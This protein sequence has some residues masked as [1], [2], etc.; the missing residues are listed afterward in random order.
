MGIAE[1]RDAI[2]LLKKLVL[3]SGC[4]IHSLPR[5]PAID[6]TMAEAR[7]MEKAHDDQ[8]KQMFSKMFA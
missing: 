5:D 7:K 1:F 3:L 2:E 6:A 8:T 4:I